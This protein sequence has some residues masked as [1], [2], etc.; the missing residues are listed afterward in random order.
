MDVAALLS[1]ND[2][3]YLDI[4]VAY[5]PGPDSPPDNDYDLYW[6]KMFCNR[7]RVLRRWECS[8][9]I[10]PHKGRDLERTIE[11]HI[12]SYRPV[13]QPCTFFDR[14]L[15]PL[16]N[17]VLTISDLLCWDDPKLVQKE[18][19]PHCQIPQFDQTE[20][21]EGLLESI[22]DAAYEWNTDEFFIE[23]RKLLR[24]IQTYLSKVLAYLEKEEHVRDKPEPPY[25]ASDEHHPEPR[26][27]M[28]VQ[29]EAGEGLVT[30]QAEDAE[31]NSIVREKTRIR[32][33]STNAFEL[34]RWL[35]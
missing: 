15:E 23:A 33:L 28:E 11:E 32:I 8:V 6:F 25:K 14:D 24:L 18:I 7:F 12:R 31:R 3:E 27:D 29:M 16:V 13:L 22:R 2:I 35:K 34:F 21:A 4:E 26:G 10:P 20:A 30:E 17:C 1:I 9:S 5:L 19:Q